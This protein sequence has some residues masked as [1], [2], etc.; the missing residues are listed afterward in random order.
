VAIILLL[1]ISEINF[2]HS[3]RARL[4]SVCNISLVA[5]FSHGCTDKQVNIHASVAIILLVVISEINFKHSLRKF[6]YLFINQSPL[7]INQIP[8]FL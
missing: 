8:C 3:L 6:I 7:K 2:K 4:K 1:V 5:G